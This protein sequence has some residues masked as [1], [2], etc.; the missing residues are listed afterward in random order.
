VEYNP[1]EPEDTRV[2]ELAFGVRGPSRP[3]WPTG[4]ALRSAGAVV[5]IVLLCIFAAYQV[6]LML[7]EGGGGHLIV[8]GIALG[9]ALAV[10]RLNAPD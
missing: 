7:S 3:S 2:L 4:R 9:V 1:D 8:I 5:V 10:W 6:P